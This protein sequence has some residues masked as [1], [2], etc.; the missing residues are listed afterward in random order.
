MF[1]GKECNEDILVRQIQD[2]VKMR[3]VGLIEGNLRQVK[4][5]KQLWD[6]GE[7][8]GW[9]IGL[10][11][12]KLGYVQFCILEKLVIENGKDAWL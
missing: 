4:R 10:L 6:L 12:V 8:I 5:M 11:K 3:I 2:M 7:G 9:R 1:N